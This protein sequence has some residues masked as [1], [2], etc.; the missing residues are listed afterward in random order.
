MD[1]KNDFLEHINSLGSVTL[2]APMSDFTTFACGGKADLL[3]IPRDVGVLAELLKAIS[4]SDLPLTVIGGGSNLLVGDRGIR[5]A[6]VAIREH[7]GSKGL[8]EITDGLVYADA[9]VKKSRFIDFCL[10]NGLGGIAFMAGIPGCIGGGIAMNA[11]A[12]EGTFSGILRRI[13]C[14][15]KKGDVFAVNTE[16]S[17]SVYRNFSAGEGVF[18]AGAF[19]ELSA[20]DADET[21]KLVQDAL[22]QRALK[23]PLEYPSAGSVFKNPESAPAWKLVEDAGFKG[24]GVGNAIVSD[25]H[26]NFI[27]NIGGARPSDIRA[28]I[29][30]IQDAVM[31]KF[32]VKLEPE[33][34][35][36][37][38][39]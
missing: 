8:I 32:S 20:E 7:A 5:G 29:E 14:I 1:I 23:H 15:D 34:R 36:I 22:A 24:R 18:V 25:K 38:E 31:K 33:I 12:N 3:I 13:A 28:L 10:K 27:V 39:F 9:M 2:N 37:G 19:F 16:A 35:M 21:A 11:G 17:M 30:L 26:S 6:V 4:Y